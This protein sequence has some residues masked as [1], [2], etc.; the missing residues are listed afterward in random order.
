VHFGEIYQVGLVEVDEAAPFG[1]G[2]I[3]L[4][5]QPG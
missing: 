5:V 1:V 2:G 4:A 3:E